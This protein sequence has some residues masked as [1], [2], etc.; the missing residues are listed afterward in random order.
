MFI[1]NN[2]DIYIAVFTVSSI[3]IR[4]KKQY[5][6]WVELF[7]YSFGKTLGGADNLLFIND[8]NKI[9]FD[10]SKRIYCF[11]SQYAVKN[12]GKFLDVK[13]AETEK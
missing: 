1:K 4:I 9:R 6:P 12:T 11:G 10:S 3:Q 13:I 7:C 5:L 2:C 8:I